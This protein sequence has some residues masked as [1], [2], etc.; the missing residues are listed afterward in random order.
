MGGKTVKN[1]NGMKVICG[2]SNVMILSVLES[3]SLTARFFKLDVSFVARFLLTNALLFV[4][5]T[6]RLVLA[7]Y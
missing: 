4:K 2:P 1:Y 7:D 3:R 5:V 6:M